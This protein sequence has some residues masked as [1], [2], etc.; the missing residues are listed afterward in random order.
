[1]IDRASEPTPVRLRHLVGDTFIYGAVD[2]SNKAVGFVLLPLTTTYLTPDDYGVVS[3]FSS[4]AQIL[5]LF[6]GMGLPISFY[7]FYTEARSQ[8]VREQIWTTACAG[9]AFHSFVL[10][11]PILFA[12]PWIDPWVFASSGP[13]LMIALV[14]VTALSTFNDLARGRLQADGR[15]TAFLVIELS[16]LVFSR[17]TMIGLIVAG[18]GIWGWVFGELVGE[19]LIWVLMAFALPRPRSVERFGEHARKLFPYGMTLVPIALSHWLMTGCDKFMLNAMVDDAKAQIG[20][21]AV[22]ERVGSIMQLFNLAFLFGWK[23]YSFG[24]MHQ[25]NGPALIAR[26]MTFY[27]VIATYVAFGLCLLGDDLLAAMTNAH[28]RSGTVVIEPLALAA[29]AWGMGEVIGVGLH[30]ARRTIHLAWLNIAAAL[31]NVALNA[32]LIPVDGIRGAATATLICQVVKMVAIGWLSQRV[33]PTPYEWRRLLIPPILFAS[34]YAIGQ[35]GVTQGPISS[36][37]FQ[38]ALLALAPI[39]L[40]PFNLLFP[41]EKDLLRRLVGKGVNRWIRRDH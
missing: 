15:S 19:G 40:A 34:L 32:L 1:M 5:L 22:G 25:A 2:V 8:P 41:E 36:T 20:F 35:F 24:N 33:W 26:G 30:K 23:R 39:L 3:L 10:L 31:A 17:A 7:R 6:C 21:Y 14:M 13:W 38:M 28:F 29:L 16:S 4:S 37:I 18:W 11:T 27:I 12:S 9:I